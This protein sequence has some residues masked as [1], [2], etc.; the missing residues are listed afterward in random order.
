M[1]NKYAY[2]FLLKHDWVVCAPNMPAAKLLRSSEDGYGNFWYRSSDR[3]EVRRFY[4][5]CVPT[6]ADEADTFHSSKQACLVG[7]DLARVWLQGNGQ[8]CDQGT[9]GGAGILRE[10]QAIGD[11]NFWYKPEMA[12]HVRS[13]Y[14]SCQTT[15]ALGDTSLDDQHC[16]VMNQKAVRYLK[17]SS[18][19]SCDTTSPGR[20]A[21]SS[22]EAAGTYWY[23]QNSGPAVEAWYTSCMSQPDPALSSAPP[24]TVAPDGKLSFPYPQEASADTATL[25]NFSGQTYWFSTGD[26]TFDDW[27]RDQGNM[28][29]PPL[30]HGEPCVT[31]AG[32]KCKPIEGIQAMHLHCGFVAPCQGAKCDTSD[33]KAI[34][35]GISVIN[36]RGEIEWLPA[37]SRD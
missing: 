25:C 18:S 10:S 26:E 23:S 29:V 31:V 33:A 19:V 2:A 36:G 20:S 27:S 4:G 28:Y 14:S 16:Q 6:C 35:G 34:Q 11:G 22:D 7:N 30:N 21:I 9:A 17:G 13:F 12:G 24:P 5:T 37:H 1:G 8:H 3:H 32:V 15:C